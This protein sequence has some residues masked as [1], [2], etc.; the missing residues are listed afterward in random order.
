MPELSIFGVKRGHRVGNAGDICL[1]DLACFD[2][3]RVPEHLDLC[4]ALVL[5]LFVFG[6]HRFL[7]LY[8]V[9]ESVCHDHFVPHGAPGRRAH[10]VL[11]WDELVLVESALKLSSGGLLEVDTVAVSH[12]VL[13][14]AL[15][16]ITVVINALSLPLHFS[17]RELSCVPRSVSPLHDAFAVHIITE[18]LTLVDLTGASEVI[19]SVAVKLSVKELPLVDITVKFEFAAACFLA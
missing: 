9:S 7:G 13:P 4:V 16:P 3:I 14:A 1:V 8:L 5:S 19:L 11:C 6:P 18:E 10:L 12:V 17:I 2:F 15:I